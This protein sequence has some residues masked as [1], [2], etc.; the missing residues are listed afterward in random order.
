[1]S[2]SIDVRNYLDP[3]FTYVHRY[4]QLRKDELLQLLPFLEIK[5]YEKKEMILFAGEID[6]YLNIVVKGMA[7]KYISLPKKR[8]VT[9]QLATEGHFI[10]SEVSFNTRRPSELSVQAVEQTILVRIEHRKLETI[11]LSFPWAENIGRLLVI[12]LAGA[13]EKRQ[14]NVRMKSARQRFLDYRTNHPQMMRRVPMNVLA[15]YLNMKPE[16]LSRLKRSVKDKF[17]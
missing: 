6:N 16:T 1:M 2:R 5:L 10:Q 12:E 7:R 4:T 15:S 13:R 9:L 11:M 8:E 3:L 17:S 14:Y